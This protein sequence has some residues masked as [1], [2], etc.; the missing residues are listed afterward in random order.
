MPGM[1]SPTK[2]MTKETIDSN[3]LV[4]L[5]TVLNI[6]H[7][8]YRS[9]PKGHPVITA[10][11]NRVIDIYSGLMASTREIE[12]IVTRDSMLVDGV[13][14]DKSN[15]VFRDFA[16]VLFERNIATIEL[17]S[18][19]SIDELNKFLII[20]GL[21]REKIQQFGGIEPVWAKARIK[22]ISIRPIRYDLFITTEETIVSAEPV[23]QNN[24]WERFAKVITKNEYYDSADE[25]DPQL[26]AAALN[27][28]YA[29]NH[30]EFAAKSSL[31]LI[32][33]IMQNDRIASLNKEGDQSYLKLADFVSHLN[34]ELRCQILSSS[35]ESSS[36]DLNPHIEKLLSSLSSEI[37]IS[38]LEDVNKNRLRIPPAVM[39]LLN[40]FV[41]N[42]DPERNTSDKI[43]N[44]KDENPDEMDDLGNRMKTLFREQFSEQF[45][46]E[47]YQAKLDLI[48]KP[49][50]IQVIQQEEIAELRDS[51]NPKLIDNKISEIILQLVMINANTGDTE[52]LADN[53]KSMCAYFLETG[54]YQ[55]LHK[56]MNDCF[57]QRLPE[58]FR[59][60]IR[61]YFSQRYFIEEI[62]FGLHTWGKSHFEQIKNVL[63]QIGEPCVEPMLD[64]LAEENSMSLR[65]FLID[66]LLEA[67]PQAGQ[68]IVTRLSDSRW[69]YLRNL[70]YIL[71]TINYHPAVETLK[72]LSHNPDARIRLE[73]I[74]TL[75]HF[76]DSSIEKLIL[77]NMDNNDHNVQLEAIHLAEKSRSPD[78]S[79]K[80]LSIVNRSGLSNSEYELKSAAVHSLGTLGQPEILPEYGRILSSRNL[81]R[82]LQL[83]KLKVDIVRSLEFYPAALAKAILAHLVNGKDEVAIQAAV[84]LKKLVINN[85]E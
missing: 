82:P 60:E 35:F 66:R 69:Y 3:T 19:L 21:N 2:N 63:N 78:I 27:Q 58:S 57:D 9:Y 80:L 64:A 76:Q 41:S 50:K 68:A 74:K 7:R 53:L 55:Q 12:I 48:M 10:S 67:G 81:I 44:I 59:N 33:N 29:N 24:L 34:P 47:Q 28:H 1:D 72:S 73:T 11:L 8:N 22:S 17:K 32:S 65:R 85:H 14:L 43:L 79:K 45:V 37:I 25:F 13:Q 75:L 30:S 23:A 36:A 84:T 83:T 77:Q 18:G 62:L 46:P 20:L 71:R 51:L 15:L 56:I 26:L 16:K 6:A 4:S 70:I 38:T 61:D 42:A 39:G 40:K 52:A 31:H 49:D 54:D 5:I